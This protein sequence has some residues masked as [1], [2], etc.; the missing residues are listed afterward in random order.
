MALATD[1]ILIVDDLYEDIEVMETGYP[2]RVRSFLVPAPDPTRGLIDAKN[3][4]LVVLGSVRPTTL[5]LDLLWYPYGQMFDGQ[6]FL[7]EALA[8]GMLQGVRLI[9]WTRF[10]DRA[11]SL[12]GNPRFVNELVRGGIASYE[13]HPK[14]VVP[15]DL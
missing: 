9:C 10:I 11:R 4:A 1:L 12:F 13:F 7:R 3:Q 14:P 6:D 5:V 8:A 15:P 2:N